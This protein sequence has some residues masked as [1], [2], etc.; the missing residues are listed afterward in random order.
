MSVSNTPEHI[1][2]VPRRSIW[3]VAEVA[4]EYGLGISTGFPVMSH[5]QYPSVLDIGANVGIFA[6]A[7][8]QKWDGARVLCFEPHPETAKLLRHNVSD[9]PVMVHET[10]IVGDDAQEIDLLDGVNH[11]CEASR[12]VL[13]SQS[14]NA[15]RKT[16]VRAMHASKLPPCDVLKIDT[17]GEELPILR[18]YPHLTTVKCVM[19]EIH[20]DGEFEP[21]H[22][23]LTRAGL[24]KQ[25]QVGRTVRYG[26]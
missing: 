15:A 25:A 21:V 26:R 1:L 2:H 17:E 5:V 6:V 20:R 4:Q 18:A 12:Y 19:A 24:H 16:R 9:M 13:D 3:Q 7:C 10:A 14:Q 23:V 11:P 22:Q 8:C